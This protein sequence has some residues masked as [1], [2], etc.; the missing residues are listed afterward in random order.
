MP[1]TGT[2]DPRWLTPLE[3]QAV[4]DNL[5]ADDLIEGTAQ[6]GSNGV[7]MIRV[8]FN[9]SA[10]RL[11]WDDEATTRVRASDFK[12]LAT[13]IGQ[14]INVDSPLSPGTQAS[15]DSAATGG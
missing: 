12:E 13:R 10:K 11:G 2:P 14:V 3:I 6:E 8:A 5:S 9:R 7:L 15:L 1:K 4:V